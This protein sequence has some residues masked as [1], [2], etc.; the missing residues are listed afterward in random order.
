[1]ALPSS[2]L[3]LPLQRKT[4]LS[5]SSFLPR[6][7]KKTKRREGKK[8]TLGG[9]GFSSFSSSSSLVFLLFLFLLPSS[10][11]S[12]FRR[13]TCVFDEKS[14]FTLI[15]IIYQPLVLFLCSLSCIFLILLLIFFNWLN[16]DFEP[17]EGEISPFL[18]RF[19]PSF[20]EERKPCELLL[21]RHIRP[22]SV[23]FRTQ[24]HFYLH[25][26]HKTCPRSPKSRTDASP[27]R[28]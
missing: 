22:A 24:T 14:F 1:M 11:S 20:E 15:R 13:C 23:I 12:S 5:L 10:S 25:H 8:R 7:N 16:P 18:K 4:S 17:D 3:F 9:G 2:L 19:S 27:S 21:A 26:T 28:L 6:Q